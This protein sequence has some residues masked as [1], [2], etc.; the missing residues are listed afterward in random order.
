MISGT[1]FLG[2][3]DSRFSGIFIMGDSVCKPR[4]T[5]NGEGGG[6]GGIRTGEVGKYL[7][8]RYD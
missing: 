3:E 5:L 8:F 1:V 2:S 4:K 6:G 7:C